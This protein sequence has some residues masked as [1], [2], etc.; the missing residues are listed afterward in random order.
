MGVR[1]TS[2]MAVRLSAAVAERGGKASTRRI[3][4]WTVEERLGPLEGTTFRVQVEHFYQ[5][6]LLAASGRSSD[7]VALQMAARGFATARLR[8]AIY[9]GWDMESAVLVKFPEPLPD[10]EL[11]QEAFALMEQLA[12]H[13]TQLS[14]NPPAPISQIVNAIRRNLK[15]AQRSADEDTGDLLKRF[16]MAM[17]CPL[18]G[19]PIYDME[20]VALGVGL[21]P[22]SFPVDTFGQMFTGVDWNRIASAFEDA[23]IGSL[24]A[25]AH[26][27][28]AY[29]PRVCSS[30]DVRLK[31]RECDVLAA[32]SAP[33]IVFALEIVRD[34]LQPAL[35]A[36]GHE[37]ASA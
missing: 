4:R 36:G 9:K 14:A 8:S 30:L 31:P 27:A 11:S 12:E 19:I 18:F 28:R 17:A 37:L 16:L 3:D 10:G 24:A 34:T 32:L 7:Q 6:S 23:P 20:P 1:R 2:E 5:L 35:V 21:P 15:A 25:A 13:H 26:W 33:L 29:V 22:D